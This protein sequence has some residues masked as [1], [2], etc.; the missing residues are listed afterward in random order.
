MNDNKNYTLKPHPKFKGRDGPYLLIIMD[1]VGIGRQD[2]GD[3]VY[4][5]KPQNLLNWTEE[6]KKNRLYVELKA[7][8]PAVGL[9]TDGDMGNAELT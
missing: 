3:A 4:H 5:A 2:E 9:P 6:A 8:G 1:G 7:H